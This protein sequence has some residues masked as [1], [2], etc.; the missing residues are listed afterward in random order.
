MRLANKNALVTGGNSG[1][2]L[3]T[4]RRF[5]AEGARVAITGRNRERL[6]AVVAEFGDRVIAIEAES[7]DAS[8]MARACQSAS[9]AFGS[10]HVLF[11]NAGI[12]GSTPLDEDSLER[13]ENIVRTNV[14]GT[15][16]TVTAALPHLA[17]GAS[18]VLTS[19]IMAGLGF[20]GTAGYAASKGALNS[21]AKVLASELSP[22]GIRVNVVS[23][24][25]IRTPIWGPDAQDAEHARL[26]TL[27][28]SIPLHRVAEAEEVANVV[29][30]LASDE[31]SNVQAAEILVD[32]GSL[33]APAG[34]PIYRQ[35]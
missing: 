11:A 14:I 21:M 25:P 28:L 24:G 13:F 35:G 27:A 22:R 33:G 15:F 1:I 34:A 20:P 10:L 9:E 23:P 29:L 16:I 17:D 3:A 18:I 7:T 2:G 8:S 26:K 30:F 12:A 19:S 5:V 4:V 32:G 6:D 31:A